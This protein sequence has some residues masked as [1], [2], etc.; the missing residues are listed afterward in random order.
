VLFRSS[1]TPMMI[2]MLRLYEALLRE[3]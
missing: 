3:Q 2:E 1:D